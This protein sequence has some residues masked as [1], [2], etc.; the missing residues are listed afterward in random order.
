MLFKI[1]FLMELQ[2]FRS[3]KPTNKPRPPKNQDQPKSF[4]TMSYWVTSELR[5]QRSDSLDPDLSPLDNGW[6]WEEEAHLCHVTISV[7][8]HLIFHKKYPTLKVYHLHISPGLQARTWRNCMEHHIRSHWQPSPSH[9]ARPGRSA[10][11]RAP[12]AAW[13]PHTRGW[14]GRSTG[15][16]AVCSPPVCSSCSGDTRWSCSQLRSRMGHLKIWLG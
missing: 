3:E 7:K 2:M 6:R 13:S 1:V 4:L 16:R 8:G 14:R 9:R 15:P 10:T 11:G 12:S 5:E